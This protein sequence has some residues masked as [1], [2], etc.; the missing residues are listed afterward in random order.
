[1]DA[2]NL[3]KIIN[4]NTIILDGHGQVSATLNLLG[5]GMVLHHSDGDEI[6]VTQ[7]QIDDATLEQDGLVIPHH[8]SSLKL[9]TYISASGAQ[10]EKVFNIERETP[11][12]IPLSDLYGILMSNIFTVDGQF[13]VTRV[14]SLNGIPILTMD[15]GSILEVI[16][17]GHCDDSNGTIEVTVSDGSVKSQVTIQFYSKLNL[18][19]L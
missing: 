13:N 1:M 15:S 16:S 7:E 9:V 11:Y 17:T 6:T 8:N 18:H 12:T 4:N 2:S 10:L 3:V 19:Q 14:L 5:D